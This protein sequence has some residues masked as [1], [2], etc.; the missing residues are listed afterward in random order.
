MVERH[1]DTLSITY[2]KPG[3]YDTDGDFTPGIEVTQLIKG[4]AEANGQGSMIRTPDGAQIVY[5]WTFWCKPQKFEAPHGSVA[6]L[7]YGAWAG[8]VKRQSNAQLHTQIW[9]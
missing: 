1:P 3:T 9:M 6:V 2:R 4:R 5:S 8:T 7:N